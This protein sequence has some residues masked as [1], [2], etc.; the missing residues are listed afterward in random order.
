MNGPQRG[1]QVG[2]GLINH[3]LNGDAGNAETSARGADR[4]NHEETHHQTGAKCT[5]TFQPGGGVGG[6]G[7]IGYDRDQRDRDKRDRGDAA[8]HCACAA[9][10][11]VHWGH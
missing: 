9:R 8:D 1:H 2:D 11:G 4:S 3:A 10:R 5:K 6:R 7:D